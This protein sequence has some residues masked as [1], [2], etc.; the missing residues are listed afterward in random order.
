MVRFVINLAPVVCGFGLVLCLILWGAGFLGQWWLPLDVLSHFRWHLVGMALVFCIA[1]VAGRFWLQA[2]TIGTFLLYV[3]IGLSP[4]AANFLARAAPDDDGGLTRLKLVSFN[5]WYENQ[6]HGA[7]EAMLREADADLVLMQ[8]FFPDKH[9][10]LEG[11]LDLYPYQVVCRQTYGCNQ[12]ILSRE[13]I[14]EHETLVLPGEL[15]VLV[16]RF[17]EKWANLSVVNIHTMRPPFF[18]L[19]L[20]QLSGLAAFAAT[21]ARPLIIAGDFN[22]TPQSLMFQTFEQGSGL[23]PLQFWPTWPAEP[24]T[25]P[26]ISIDH[27]FISSDLTVQEAARPLRN[28]GSDHLPITVTVTLP[29]PDA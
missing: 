3:G 29:A 12:V 20:R 11:L 7:I 18:E 4:L 2:L 21:M 25:L 10:L 8:E 13:P 23:V 19:Q 22:A 15:P 24:W 5:T 26:Q 27:I 14:M 16:A 9:H 28:A 17:G 1:G 6:D